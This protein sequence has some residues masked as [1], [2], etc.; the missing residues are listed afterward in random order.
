MATY[1]FAMLALALPAALTPVQSDSRLTF[2]GMLFI[3]T[4]MLPLFCMGV[5]RTLGTIESLMMTSRSE[6]ILPFTLITIIY[7]AI[8]WV[9]YY[10]AGLSFDDNFM[11][12]LL[13]I[14]MLVLVS[15]VTTLFFKVSIHSVGIWGL[16]GIVVP[17][18]RIS[19][20]NAMLYIST[21]LIFVAGL[22]MAS[23]LQLGAHT[24]RE[25]MWG[26]ILGLATSITGMLIL[27]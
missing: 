22:V 1:L 7:F 3:V 26:A 23:R 15:T 9:F 16:V 21:A 11:K 10:N 14:D 17:L 8:T 5:F 2:I 24:S 25:V 6:R 27:F 18:T 13:V 20:V 12:L 4:F 19:E